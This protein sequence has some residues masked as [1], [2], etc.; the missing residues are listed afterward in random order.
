MDLLATEVWFSEA[1]SWLKYKPDSDKKST[2]LVVKGR[3]V[4]YLSIFRLR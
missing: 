3:Y 2:L 1:G 4:W